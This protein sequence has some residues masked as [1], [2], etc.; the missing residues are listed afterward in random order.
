M[1]KYP[2][3]ERIIQVVS[4]YYG[5]PDEYIQSSRRTRSVA[6]PRQVVFWLADQLTIMSKGDIGNRV[7]GSDHATV[8]YG[9]N[10]VNT[11]DDLRKDA[12]M[13]RSRLDNR[14]R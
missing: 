7:N 10:M 3:I 5:I 13:L 4:A 14:D 1:N 9:C 8:H 2:P 11:R 12:E 6:R